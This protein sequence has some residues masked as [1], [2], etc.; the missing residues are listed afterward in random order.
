MSVLVKDEQ[1]PLRK[2]TAEKGK[3]RPMYKF[4]SQN[5]SIDLPPETQHRMVERNQGCEVCTELCQRSI[6]S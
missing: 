3:S 2:S 6:P 5:T 1:L 4:G